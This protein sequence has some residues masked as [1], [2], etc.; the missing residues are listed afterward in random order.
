[1]KKV[2]N[3]FVSAIIV[4]DENAHNLE[5]KVNSTTKLLKARYTNYEVVVVNN[6]VSQKEL[7]LLVKLLPKVACIRIIQLS[8][9][10][11]TDTAVFA[12]LEAAIGDIVC[13]LYNDDPVEL[14]PDFV[15]KLKSHDIVFGVATDIKRGSW[16]ETLGARLFYWY[17]KRYLGINIPNGSTYFIAMNRNVVNAI[18]HNKRNRRHIRHIAKQVGFGSTNLK[19]SLPKKQDAY[20]NMNPLALV[21]RAIDLV[22]SYSSHPL[23][24]LTYFGVLAGLLNLMYAFY[25]IIVNISV[26]DIE[27]GWTSTSLQSSLMFFLLFMILAILAEYIGKILNEV[28]GEPPYHVMSELSSTVSIADETRRNVTK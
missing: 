22:S 25:V 17:S 4:A 12:G 10:D 9:V 3:T 1:M 19:Y 2:S 15:E 14:I 13:I 23:R 21:S 6:G 11:D 16:L 27:K 8:R 18:T 7:A 20:S 24:L 26:N 5:K 28:Q